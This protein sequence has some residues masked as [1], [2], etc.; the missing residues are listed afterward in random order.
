MGEAVGW[1]RLLVVTDR[2]RLVARAGGPL[3]R[4]PDLLIA[5]V[6]GAL[7]GG[8]DLVQIR[9]RDLDAGVLV[10][11]LRRLFDEVPEGRSRVV[12]NDRADVALVTGAAGVHLTARSVTVAD[13]RRL[14][15][16][17]RRWVVGQSVHSAAAAQAASGAAYVVVGT[18][19]RSDS[20]PA[21]PALGWSGLAEIARSV[22]ATP[23]VAIGGLRLDDVV[24]LR[25]AGATGLGGIGCFLPLDGESVAAGTEA[26]V[27]AFRQAF[28]TASVM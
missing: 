18:V 11:F 5:Q 15:P 13:A 21:A 3:E 25:R 1:P 9:E 24:Q 12:V 27:R 20:K 16:Q 6:A 2:H 19:L 17:G 23:V 14:A 10:R 8:A 28:E 26:R 4:W 22:G 7:E